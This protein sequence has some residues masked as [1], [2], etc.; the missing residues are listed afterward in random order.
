MLPEIPI[1]AIYILSPWSDSLSLNTLQYSLVHVLNLPIS[2]TA[3]SS[4]KFINV[5][6]ILSPSLIA[7]NR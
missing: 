5:I 6:A 7:I 2:C 3:I 4:I 1:F